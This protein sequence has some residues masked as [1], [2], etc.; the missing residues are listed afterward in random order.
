MR[1][2]RPRGVGT[3]ARIEAPVNRQQRRRISRANRKWIAA[4]AADPSVSHEELLV[5]RA[6]AERATADGRVRLPLMDPR[7][8]GRAC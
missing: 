3:P 4:V 1:T 5:A 8:R 2:G 7:E 6:I